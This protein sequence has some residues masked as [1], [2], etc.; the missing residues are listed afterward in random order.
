MD[1]H[2][3]A[4]MIQSKTW[5]TIVPRRHDS[6]STSQACNQCTCSFDSRERGDAGDRPFR[7]HLTWITQ[8]EDQPQKPPSGV[9]VS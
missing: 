3:G 5:Q 6:A 4:R 7:S 9:D 2:L 8:G 1:L